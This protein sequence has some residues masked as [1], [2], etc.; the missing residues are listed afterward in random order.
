MN[1]VYILDYSSGNIYHFSINLDDLLNSEEITK[2]VER[3]IEAK[4]FSL[5][6]ISYMLTDDKINIEEV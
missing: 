3:E 4:D 6:E 2:I 1:E 5:D